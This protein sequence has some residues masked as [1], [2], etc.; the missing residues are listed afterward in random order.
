MLAVSLLPLL[1][2]ALGGAASS[3]PR[4]ALPELATIFGLAALYFAAAKLGLSMAF[5]A[6]QVTA[7]WPPT[8]IA[9]AAVLLLGYRV[10]PGIWLGAFLANATAHEPFAAA[11]G[12]AVGNTLE[13]VLGAWLL[14]RFVGFGNTLGRLRDVL[15]LSL[16]AACLSPTVSATIGVTSLALGGMQPWSA[17]GAIWLVWWLGDATGALVTAPLLLTWATRRQAW[18]RGELGEAAALLVAL[19]AVSLLVFT[20]LFGRVASHPLEYTVFPFVIWAALRF[21]QLGTATVIFVLS[22]IAIWGTV[23]GFGPFVTESVHQ[24][25]ILL[26]LFMAVVAVSGLVLAA[27]TNERNIA[28]RRRAADYA[29]GQALARSAS[30]GD[31]APRILRAMCESLDWDVGALWTVDPAGDVLRCVDVWHRSSDRFTRFATATR[32]RTFAPGVGLPG[33]VWSSGT[34]AWVIDVTRD[35]NFPRAAVAAAEGLHGAFAFPIVLGSRVLGVLEA[36]SREIQAPD[37]DLLLM[38]TA[39]GSQVGQFIEHQRTELLYRTLADTVPS[40]VFT[41]HADGRCD[42]WNQRWYDYT[43]ATVEASQGF[44]WLSAV[45]P[46]DA[47]RCREEWTAAVRTGSPFG[48]EYRL[49]AVSGGYHWFLARCLP[50]RDSQGEI[51]RW[52]G[53]CTDIDDRKRGE[54]ALREASRIKDEFLA[55]LGHELRNPVGAISNAIHVLNHIAKPDDLTGKVRGIIDRQVHHLSRLLDDLLDVSRITSGKI[56]LRRR[57][58]DVLDACT[59]ALTALQEE[60]KTRRHDITLRGEPL[61][62]DGDPVRLEQ[63]VRNLVDNAAK[64]TPPGGRI[65]VTLGPEDGKA[66]LRVRDTGAGMAREVIPLVFDVF[67][68]GGQPLDRSQGGLGLGLSLVKR[69]VELH[70]G[71][72]AASSPGPGQGSE[73]VIRLPLLTDARGAGASAEAAAE[74]LTRRTVLLVEDNDDFREGLRALLEE[75]GQEVEAAA[76]GRR[77]LE[78]ALRLRPDVALIDVGLPGLDGYAVAR[79]IRAAPGGDRTRLVALT[80]YGRVEDRQRA[81][82]AG[83]DAHLAKPVDVERLRQILASSDRPTA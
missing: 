2:R 3:A 33:R 82:E 20:G 5:V 57:A 52:V 75:W 34:A 24:S 13:A 10:W 55:M 67:V 73:F 23:N 80:G 72:V 26:Q 79:G 28:A 46:D 50:V 14:R 41:T 51:A 68:Q 54:D 43:G 76:D 59:R 29:I 8:G 64:Y 66:V 40:M 21:G 61:I 11:T 39:V 65:D 19:V 62:V 12:I 45:H 69:L 32:G 18:Q 7:V 27:S 47:P 58:V 36:F 49:R 74:T 35:D 9:L 17:F 6:E 60:G 78:I 30:L 25:L 71:T 22:G 4:P 42:Y 44:G 37:T 83:F 63:I 38:M 31:A 15:G 1:R 16:L 53:T 56:E 48:V 77:G 81:E 70:G